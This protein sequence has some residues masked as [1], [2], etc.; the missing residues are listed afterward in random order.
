MSG[1]KAELFI[2]RNCLG[3]PG[4]GG[5]AYII[6]YWDNLNGIGSSIPRLIEGTQGFRLT[7]SNQMEITSAIYGVTSVVDNINSI[8]KI[9]QVNL[10]CTSEY[11]M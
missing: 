1:V 10:Y 3:N 11:L 7:T 4:A 9:N 5:L 2:A 8:K 6:Q